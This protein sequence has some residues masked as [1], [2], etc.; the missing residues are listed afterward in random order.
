MLWRL[1]DFCKKEVEDWFETWELFKNERRSWREQKRR[2]LKN[3]N[4]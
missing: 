1:F 3:E 2:T 4:R